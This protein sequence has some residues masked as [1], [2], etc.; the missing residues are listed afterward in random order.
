[1]E[2]ARTIARFGV[3]FLCYLI[4]ILPGIKQKGLQLFYTL[5]KINIK[6][7]GNSVQKKY[8]ESKGEQAELIEYTY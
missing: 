1:M 5:H 8:A 7:K 4:F 6:L 3:I 2:L